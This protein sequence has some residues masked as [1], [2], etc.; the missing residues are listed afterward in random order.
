MIGGTDYSYTGNNRSTNTLS[1]LDALAAEI[2]S[3]ADIWQGIDEGEPTRFTIVDGYIYFDVPTDEDWTGRNVWIDYYKTAQRYS[4]DNA[5]LLMND[6]GVYIYWLEKEI[7][8]KKSS[9]ELPAGDVSQKEYERR[10]LQLVAKDKNPYK[11][12]IVPS[13][14][15]TM[16]RRPY[17][18]RY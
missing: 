17:L 5:A 14:P 13:V 3:G 4:S 6:P 2:T 15:Y 7:K 9:G 11:L 12:R 1:G 10:K 8:R 18:N 16:S